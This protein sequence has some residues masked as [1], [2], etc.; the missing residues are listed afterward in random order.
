MIKYYN[1]ELKINIKYLSYQSIIL[2]LYLS[3]WSWYFKNII[4]FYSYYIFH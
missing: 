1:H 4:E 3:E 2:I